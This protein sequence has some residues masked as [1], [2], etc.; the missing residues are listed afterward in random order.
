M[1]NFKE[2]TSWDLVIFFFG[3]SPDFEIE[4]IPEYPDLELLKSDI[5][6]DDLENFD[7][8]VEMYMLR[9]RYVSSA[10]LLQHPDLR[11]SFEWAGLPHFRGI[12]SS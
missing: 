7:T 11:T 2:I 5:N 12:H 1:P 10:D 3:E 8:E 6:P 9:M 4:K